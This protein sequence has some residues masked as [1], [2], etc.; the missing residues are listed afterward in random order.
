MITKKNLSNECVIRGVSSSIVNV[1][2]IKLTLFKAKNNHLLLFLKILQN[3][4][5]PLFIILKN[6]LFIN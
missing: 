6:C 5:Y 4:I 3:N 1:D 2:Q